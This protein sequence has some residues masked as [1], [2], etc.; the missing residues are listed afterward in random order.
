MLNQTN[1]PERLN[2]TVAWTPQE[3]AELFRLHA[4]GWGW[5]A[6][7]RAM[8]RSHSGVKSKFKYEMN[9]REIKAPSLP[10]VRDPVPEGVLAEQARRL[11]AWSER[12]LTATI[13]GDPAPEWA[14]LARR[15]V[16]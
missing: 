8:G 5:H 16:S 14:A 15:G 10:G 12:T 2:P 13:C 4:L 11:A 7:G 6:I 9:N 3:V 1:Q